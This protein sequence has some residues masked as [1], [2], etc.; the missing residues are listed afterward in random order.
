MHQNVEKRFICIHYIFLLPEK[1][2]EEYKTVSCNY[3]SS[4]W[5]DVALYLGVLNIRRAIRFVIC[6][7]SLGSPKS[8]FVILC[9]HRLESPETKLRLGSPESKFVIKCS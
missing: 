9:W 1:S 5:Y 4:L 7:L 8:K 2:Y 6:Q 3:L